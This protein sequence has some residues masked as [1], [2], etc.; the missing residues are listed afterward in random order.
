VILFPQGFA[1]RWFR[2]FLNG[3]TPQL[4]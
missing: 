1:S 2:T 4:D 3:V